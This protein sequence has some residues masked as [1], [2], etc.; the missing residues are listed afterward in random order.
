MKEHYD[1]II[2]GSGFGGSVS[3]LR[4]AEKGYRVLVLE[5]GKW[6]RAEDFPKNNWHLNKWLWLPLL[7]WFGILKISVFRH[8]SVVSGCGVGGGSLVYANTL[9]VP[10]TAFFNSGSWQR[11]K[12]WETALKPFYQQALT[13]LGAQ[14]SPRLFDGDKTLAKLAAERNQSANFEQP[15]VA[16][17]FGEPSVTVD[18]PYFNGKGPSRSGCNFCGAC[19]T[20]CRYNAKNTLDKN[21]LYLAQQ[22]GAEIQAQKQVTDVVAEHTD[23]GSQ[24]YIVSYRQ[25]GA[26]FGK[27]QQLKTKGVIFS[28][29]VLGTVKLL[30]KLK[31]RSL[32]RLSDKVGD[33]I[34][35]NSESLITVVNTEGDKNF[36]EGI[37]I[38]S[39][40]HAS[41]HS[42]V[43]ACRYGKGSGFWRIAHLPMVQGHHI[44]GRLWQ[45]LTKIVSE[46]INYLKLYSVKDW[47]NNSI[48]LLFMQSLDGTLLFRRNGFGATSSSAQ[49]GKKPSPFIPEAQD[50]AN[51][52]AKLSHGKPMTFSLETLFGAPVT[53]HIL[54]G[55]VMGA[56]DREGVID[57]HNRVFN[58]QNMYVCDGSM[59]SANPGVNPSLSITAITEHAMSHIP[60]KTTPE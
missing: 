48:I 11:L 1:F 47:A 9:P 20:G 4:L 43:E 49:Q 22:H 30:L 53:A 46:P 24:G 34:R 6:Y 51:H 13:M 52:Y 21:Y 5:Q 17:F 56:S 44:A 12:D 7:R 58:Y 40:F 3:A 27:T 32:P 50:I 57:Q 23:D 36:A 41:E 37:A 39:F 25:T 16:V 2:I 19:M 45:V 8:V 55:A 42:H 28:G 59:I 35:T 10:K 60:P 14:Q 31:K 26:L 33:D 18:D 38:G 29:G 54:G 15:N